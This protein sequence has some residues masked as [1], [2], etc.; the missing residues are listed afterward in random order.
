MPWRNSQW[1]TGYTGYTDSL[2]LNGNCAY[3][4]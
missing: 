2:L 1:V 3:L 4:H